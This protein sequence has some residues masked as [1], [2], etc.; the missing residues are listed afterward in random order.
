MDLNEIVKEE[1]EYFKDAPVWELRAVKKALQMMSVF[2]TDEENARLTAVKE[3][4]REK[5]K[6]ENQCEI[7]NGK[8]VKGDTLCEV[9]I[10]EAE[11]ETPYHEG[12]E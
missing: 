1:K 10:R 5:R 8:A 4:L 11:A 3:L 9:C 2:N 7:C 12:W 6:K